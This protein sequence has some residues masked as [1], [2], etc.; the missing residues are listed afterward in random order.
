[1]LSPQQRLLQ[2]LEEEF[3]DKRGALTALDAGSRQYLIT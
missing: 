2:A 1:M 3:E